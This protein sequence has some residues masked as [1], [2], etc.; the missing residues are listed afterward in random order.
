MQNIEIEKILAKIKL[1]IELT[2][3]EYKLYSLTLKENKK[4]DGE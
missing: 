4:E 2:E 1:G 3:D